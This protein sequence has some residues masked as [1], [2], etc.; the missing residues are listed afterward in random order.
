MQGY[1]TDGYKLKDFAS[2]KNTIIDSVRSD[3]ETELAS[4][5]ETLDEQNFLSPLELKKFFFI[6]YYKLDPLIRVLVI[7]F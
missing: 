4:V 3:Y 2:V 6:C 1:K 5:L 7:H